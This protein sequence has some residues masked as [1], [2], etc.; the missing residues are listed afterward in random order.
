MSPADLAILKTVVYA[1]LFDYPLR[2][3]ELC[4]GLFDL[5]LSPAE[6]RGRLDGSP[7]LSAVVAERDGFVFLAGREPL[8]GARREGERRAAELLARHRGVLARIARLPYVRLLA[9]S[10]AVAFDN[11]HDDDL[12]LFVVARAGRAWSAC[13][14]VT[15]LARLVGARRAI[16]ANY[17]LDEGSLALAD[18]DLYT[19][20]QLAHLRPVAGGDAHRRFVEANAWV[21]G[22][23]PAAYAAS[24]AAAAPPARVGLGERILALGPGALLEAAS[25]RVLTANLRRKIPPGA[26]PASV[27]LGPGRLKLHI[28]DHRPATIARFERALAR[29]LEAAE[30]AAAPLEATRT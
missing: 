12:D 19:A 24:L 18:R 29:A 5:A 2:F 28:N 10:G 30:R 14:L 15:L 9:L 20:H 17:F 3:E 27:R 8:L 4:R 13:L 22:F 1:D 16:C 11:V 6:V 23:F 26:D 25:R 21:E 7:E